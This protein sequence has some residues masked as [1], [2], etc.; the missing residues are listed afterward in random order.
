MRRAHI[1]HFGEVIATIV[2]LHVHVLAHTADWR[3]KETD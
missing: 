3:M 2:L 1:V